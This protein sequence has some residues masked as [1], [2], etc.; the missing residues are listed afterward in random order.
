[1]LHAED[2]RVGRLL[3]LLTAFTGFVDWAPAGMPT[4]LD[5]KYTLMSVGTLLIFVVIAWDFGPLTGRLAERAAARRAAGA[6][7]AEAAVVQESG[8]GGA[9]AAVGPKKPASP[10]SSRPEKPWL[11]P[12]GTRKKKKRRS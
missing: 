7:L 11:V 6:P 3:L 9:G 5:E 2:E 12:P 8:G 4:W 1:L 10:V